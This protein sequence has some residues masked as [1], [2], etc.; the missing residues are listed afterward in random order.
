MSLKF[1]WKIEYASCCSKIYS[2]FD[3]RTEKKSSGRLTATPWTLVDQK[4]S[5]DH[6]ERWNLGL[7]LEE[8]NENS[9][10]M[11]WHSSNFS[12]M[13]K[14]CSLFIFFDLSQ[15]ETVKYVYYQVKKTATSELW[16]ITH[17]SYTTMPPH[18]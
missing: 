10:A 1:D 13:S 6:N 11:D 14:W 15:G 4:H 7:R 5:K 12:P 3:Y 18:N 8:W 9:V 17:G 2:W 16:Q